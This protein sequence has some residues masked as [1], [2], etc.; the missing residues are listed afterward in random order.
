MIIGINVAIWTLFGCCCTF[1]DRPLLRT[2]F[3]V[4]KLAVGIP[5]L[6][7]ELPEADFNRLNQDFKSLFAEWEKRWILDGIDQLGIV[8]GI[9]APDWVPPPS[10][11][12]RQFLKDDSR[13]AADFLAKQSAEQRTKIE[14]SVERVSLLLNG[15]PAY[16]LKIK[17]EDE[18]DLM[19]T[20]ERHLKQLTREIRDATT[21]Q[22]RGYQHHYY[23]ELLRAIPDHVLAKLDS[24]LGYSHRKLPEFLCRMNDPFAPPSLPH[25]I[26]LKGNDPI[27]FFDN[28]S[29]FDANKLRDW[30]V[31]GMDFG[32]TNHRLR[33]QIMYRLLEEHDTK[34]SKLLASVK[35]LAEL[36]EA[37]IRNLP[38]ARDSNEQRFRM[39][40][41]VVLKHLNDWCVGR[42]HLTHIDR[43]FIDFGPRWEN[44]KLRAWPSQLL[45][46]RNDGF[47]QS[48]RGKYRADLEFFSGIDP[49]RI[50]ELARLADITASQAKELGPLLTNYF[51][52]MKQSQD[53]NE[54]VTATNHMFD[55]MSKILIPI[56]SA[57]FV[58]NLIM[59]EGLDLL[60]RHPAVA[61][62]LS[63]T[64]TEREH[65][66][67]SEL[68]LRVAWR[69]KHH[70]AHRQMYQS[71]CNGIDPVDLRKV[72]SRTELEVE[73]LV[74]LLMTTPF[75]SN[76][77]VRLQFAEALNTESFLKS[78]ELHRENRMKQ[79]QELMQQIEQANQQRKT[80]PKTPSTKSDR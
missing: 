29:T 42:L 18:P 34:N 32:D 5:L 12:V 8:E 21:M 7:H 41:K 2:D 6:Q 36:I 4:G 72:L 1:Q 53:L 24:S 17:S 46:E 70:G 67:T 78:Y 38:E 62:E 49:M 48:S 39:R 14:A 20:S 56:Q 51:D 31:D 22:L 28:I 55:E 73:Q 45:A 40:L 69:E 23:E 54:R 3:Q 76:S 27:A 26:W 59:S 43:D 25:D 19:E 13:W 44:L 61:R 16:L 74:N 33:L 71:L 65:F 80:R 30:L 75:H 35:Q 9:R 50:R 64:P 66:Q 68:S 58:H 77:I 10:Q 11:T 47:E 60:L 79:N 57:A 37:A 15:L 63:M 52:L